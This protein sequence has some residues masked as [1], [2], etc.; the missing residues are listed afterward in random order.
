[1]TEANA[2][3][4]TISP[5]DHLEFWSN[6]AFQARSVAEFLELKN[7]EVAKIAGVAK[8]S[9]RY[10][11]EIPRDLRE[12]LEEIANICNL[13]AQYFE[14]DAGKTALWFRT[15]NPILGE[16]SPRDMIRFGRYDKL[17]RFIVGAQMD[18]DADRRAIQRLDSTRNSE[19]HTEPTANAQSNAP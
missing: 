16:I 14:G 8:S 10:D 2:L 13:V 17:R 7:S 4:R 9:V 6:H 12:R 1:M 19:N 5:I 3:F 15:K 18:R 11:N